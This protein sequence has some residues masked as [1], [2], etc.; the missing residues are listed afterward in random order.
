VTPQERL[1]AVGRELGE[2]HADPAT[3][4]RVLERIRQTPEHRRAIARAQH[5]HGWPS[6]WARLADRFKARRGT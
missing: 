3:A 2:E 6:R 4:A 5:R 1:R